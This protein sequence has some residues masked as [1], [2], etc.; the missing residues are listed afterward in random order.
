MPSLKELEEDKDGAGLAN[1]CFPIVTGT[2]LSRLSHT[3]SPHASYARRCNWKTPSWIQWSIF[4]DLIR[5]TFVIVITCFITTVS[6]RIATT[7][8]ETIKARPN[9]LIFLHRVSLKIVHAIPTPSLKYYSHESSRYPHFLY[10]AKLLLASRRLIF[11]KSHYR[12]LADG[13]SDRM[14]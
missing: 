13:R 2:S 9:T 10:I 6:S 14:L 3:P 11:H 8:S 1:I 5:L 4:R 7:A 12:R